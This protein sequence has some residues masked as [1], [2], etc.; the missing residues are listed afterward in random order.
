MIVR[1]KASWK[2]MATDKNLKRLG[3]KKIWIDLDNSPH[4]P[5]FAPII[6]ELQ[7]LGHSV[8]VTARDC[9]QVCELADLFGLEYRRIGRHY[10]KN[11]LLKLAGLCTRTL[12]LTPTI[13]H[14]KPDLAISHGSRAQL[15]MSSLAGVPSVVI[16]D[17]EFAKGLVLMKPGWVM[18]PEVIPDAAIQFDADRILKYPGIKEDVYVPRFRPD[19]A[20]RVSLGLKKEDVVATVRPPASEAHYH[21]PLSEELFAAVIDF[22]GSHPNIKVILLPRNRSQESSL[23]SSYPNLFA[24][25]KL[26]VPQHAID[27][28]NLMWHSDAVISGG[29]TMNREAAALG[30]PV[31]S[32]FGG[33]IGAVDRYLADA[34]RLVLI[35]TTDDVRNKI[36]VEKQRR[37]PEPGQR[38]SRALRA[39]VDNL[40]DILEP[41][42]KPPQLTA[43]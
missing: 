23:R 26:V 13:L 18:V 2:F 39:I 43:Q 32:I 21:K 15:L 28:L 17:Y 37:P 16:I 4:V 3:S 20:I 38:S 30:I 31:F 35:Q 36:V 25:G 9:F 22:L 33:Q 11:K 1:P 42:C 34:G 27:G 40:V 5:F 12:Q 24:A 29:G 10:G 14:E 7:R 8:F 41:T 19:P 6:E